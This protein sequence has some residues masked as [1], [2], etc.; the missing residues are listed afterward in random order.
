MK[1][2]RKI[3]LSRFRRAVVNAP[4]QPRFSSER[5]DPR[6]ARAALPRFA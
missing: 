6:F 5:T 2:T 3:L 4:A 1:T